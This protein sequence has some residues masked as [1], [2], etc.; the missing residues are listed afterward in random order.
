M[1]GRIKWENIVVACHRCNQWRGNIA[2]DDFRLLIDE[3]RRT[4][5]FP[6]EKRDRLFARMNGKT[7]KP[8][9]KDTP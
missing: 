9:T 5:R 6:R 3:Y 4:G 2:P 1:G 7:L 8:T